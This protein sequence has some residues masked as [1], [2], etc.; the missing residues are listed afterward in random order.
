[1]MKRWT[2]AVVIALLTPLAAV[3]QLTPD[4][5]RALEV[6]PAVVLRGRAVPGEVDLR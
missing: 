3:G 2:I 1:M 5:K 4:E 6:K